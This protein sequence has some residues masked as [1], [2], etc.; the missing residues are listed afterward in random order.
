M[1][2]LLGKARKELK[3]LLN[4]IPEEKKKEIWE[5]IEK[6]ALEALKVYINSQVNRK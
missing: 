5:N 1:F 3:I 2:L 4:S 6:I